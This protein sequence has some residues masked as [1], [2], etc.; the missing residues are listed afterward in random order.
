VVAVFGSAPDTGN[1]GVSAL[2]Y[3]TLGGL[4]RSLD[5]FTPVVF[6]HGI[7]IRR[8]TIDFTSREL[9]V[10]R[11]GAYHTKRLYRPESLA[12]IRASARLGNFGSPASRL[13]ARSDAVLDLSGGDSFT[14][15]YG[16]WRFRSITL[17]K[18]IALEMG[19]P[20][21]LLPQTYGPF[22]D[23]GRRRIAQDILR[24][25]SLAWARDPW[26]YARLQE[27]LGDTF[28]PDR[29]REGVDV[30]F[31][32]EPKPPAEPL[33]SPLQA[34]LDDPKTQVAGI[35]VSGLLFHGGE[36][37][38]RRYGLESDYRAVVGGLISRLLE[39]TDCALLLVPHVVVDEEHHE[40]DTSAAR[41][42]WE[43]LGR[44]DRV[45]VAPSYGDP[46]HA[47]WLISKLDWFCGTRMHSTIAALSSGVPAAAMAYSDKTLGVFQTCGQGDQVVDLRTNSTDEINDHMLGGWQAREEVKSLLA[48][49]LPV[50]LDRARAQMDDLAAAIT[51]AA[52]PK[53]NSGSAPWP[54]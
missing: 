6:D 1:L 9:T 53:S 36:E 22:S 54:G 21:F 25:A 3:G 18:L 38:R 39:E 23:P 32:L 2:L 13:M 41:A 29:H 30:A 50:V 42:I 33:P 47:K 8:E 26:S 52:D 46:R 49:G 4:S 35:N 44:S 43:E 51:G 48:Q 27:L 16:Q 12:R 11:C 20:L 10:V 17:P 24:R 7:G 15:L 31:L 28:D 5:G 14:D 45:M 34:W 40:S 37:A 19:R